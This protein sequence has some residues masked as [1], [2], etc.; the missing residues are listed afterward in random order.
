MSYV[1]L[2]LLKE[3]AEALNN[4]SSLILILFPYPWI[5]YFRNWKY[6]FIKA[7]LKSVPNLYYSF[8]QFFVLL[9][10]PI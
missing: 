2:Q 4:R 10:S 6:F 3:L 7:P 1:K 9:F 8:N 5:K